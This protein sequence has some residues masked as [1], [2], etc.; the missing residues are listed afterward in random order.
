V[1]WWAWTLLWVVLVLGALVVFA[2]AGRSLWRKGMALATELGTAADR[3]AEVSEQLEAFGDRVARHPE[4]AVFADPVDLRRERSEQRSE[5]ARLR[6]RAAR[7][8]REEA[9]GGRSPARRGAVH[10][11]GSRAT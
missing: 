10:P 6:A 9:D 5:Q 8:R 11:P 1:T 7:R 2:L 3:F 4:L